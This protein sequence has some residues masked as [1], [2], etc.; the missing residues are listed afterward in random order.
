MKK[1]LAIAGLPLLMGGC[2]PLLPLPI[3][4]ASTGLSGLAILT[5]GKSTTDH[6]ISAARDQDC[7]V[8]RVAFGDNICQRYK[9]KSAKPLTVYDEEFPGDHEQWRQY[10]GPVPVGDQEGGPDA[11]TAEVPEDLIKTDSVDPWLVSSLAAPISVTPRVSLDFSDLQ[12]AATTP[13]P[14]EGVGPWTEPLGPVAVETVAL[15]P[16]PKQRPS[17]NA[18]ATESG[19]RVNLPSGQ[20]VGKFLAL[21]SFRASERADQ[22]S[23]RFSHLRPRIMTVEIDGRRWNRVTVGPLSPTRARDLRR[24]YARIDG[25]NTWTFIKK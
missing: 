1:A 18:A 2:I 8:H 4:I 20:G 23:R 13:P 3:S 22:L 5:T 11:N 15:P 16:L 10:A 17:S 6:V 7:A 12:G 14:D 21:G 9:S 25:K 19:T 24:E